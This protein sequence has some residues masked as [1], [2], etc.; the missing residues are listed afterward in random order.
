LKVLNNFF[1][2]FLVPGNFGM[3]NRENDV[4]KCTDKKLDQKL[5]EN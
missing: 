5:P 3:E 1:K 4:R 2:L